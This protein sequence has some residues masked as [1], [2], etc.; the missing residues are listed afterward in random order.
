M[1]DKNSKIV[2]R[3]WIKSFNGVDKFRGT[4]FF[5]DGDI[6]V[7][8]KH[9]L[10]KGIEDYKNQE[11]YITINDKIIPVQIHKM[12]K[13]DIAILKIEQKINISTTILTIWIY[14]L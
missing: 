7:T 1:D 3:V 10:T 11:F 14:M 2:V 8:A 4:A 9:V 5:I 12:C 13:I 6:L